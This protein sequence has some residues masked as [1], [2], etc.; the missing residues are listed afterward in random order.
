MKH[1][2]IILISCFMINTSFVYSQQ[3][4]NIRDTVNFQKQTIHSPKKA[5]LMSAVLPGLGQIYNRK[6]WKVPIIYVGL[7]GFTY[8]AIRNQSTFNSF[9]QAYIDRSN[10]DIDE[11]YGTY[12][13]QGLLNEMDAYRRNRDLNLLG[14]LLIYILQIVDANVDANLFDFDVSNDLSFRI[15]PFPVNDPLAQSP[16]SGMRLSLRF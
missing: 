1:F 12:T 4:E 8:M 16:I 13:D 3:S 7:G 2:I 14:D 5:T 10:G 9:K 11:Y 6:T 15:E